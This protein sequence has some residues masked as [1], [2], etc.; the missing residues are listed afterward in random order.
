MTDKLN[1]TPNGFSY[2]NKKNGDLFYLHKKEVQLRSKTKQTI[3]YFSGTV[4]PD[5]MATMPEGYEVWENPNTGMPL[6]KKL[7][8]GE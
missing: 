5:L 6:L 1:E 3:F 8:G 2:R 7:K 4:T